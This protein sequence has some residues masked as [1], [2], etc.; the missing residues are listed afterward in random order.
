ME[1]YSRIE[2]LPEVPAGIIE[3]VNNNNL[4]VFIGAGVSRIIGCMGWRELAVNL[5]NVCFDTQ[6]KD[7]TGT[8]IN[9]K[10]KES[11]LQESDHKKVITICI[12]CNKTLN[13]N[14]KL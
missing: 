7:N 13:C 11:L 14:D 4:V 10:E 9:F 6:D 12:D 5:I 2:K 1:D 3:A 8:C